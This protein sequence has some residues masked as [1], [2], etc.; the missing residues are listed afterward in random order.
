MKDA[1]VKRLFRQ[2]LKL[3]GVLRNL[4]AIVKNKGIFFRCSEIRLLEYLHYLNKK[5]N[6]TTEQATP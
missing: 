6:T 1:L 4:T 2:D 3:K 5:R